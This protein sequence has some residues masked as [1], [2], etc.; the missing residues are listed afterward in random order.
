MT[1]D[2]LLN[3]QKA[4]SVHKKEG[5][6]V[7]SG[8]PSIGVSSEF[9]AKQYLSKSTNGEVLSESHL[10]LTLA[11]IER[12]FSCPAN[13]INLA[14]I[15]IHWGQLSLPPEPEPRMEKQWRHNIFLP[16][17]FSGISRGRGKD[18]QGN[19]WNI[20]P[21]NMNGFLYRDFRQERKSKERR[22]QWECGI[23]LEDVFGSLGK[24]CS[25]Y[26]RIYFTSAL[27]IPRPYVENNLF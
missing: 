25:I 24:L 18:G 1:E 15:K 5:F 6:Q 22:Q 27:L 13:Q 12:P 23:F 3:D 21:A 4:A 7:V 26:A 11:L 10:Y 8:V 2:T 19:Y 14:S 9:L 16:N 17:C 20:Y